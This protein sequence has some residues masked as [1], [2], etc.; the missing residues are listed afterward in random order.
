[1]RP[2]LTPKLALCVLCHLDVMCS[3]RGVRF[4]NATFVAQLK[5]LHSELPNVIRGLEA[6]KDGI[7][8]LCVVPSRQLIQEGHI[9]E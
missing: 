8:P 5:W 6:A 9:S 3:R 1:M 7:V 2:Y 4:D